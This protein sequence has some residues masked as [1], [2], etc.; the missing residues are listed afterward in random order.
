MIDDSQ[1]QRDVREEL[2]WVPDVD[3][4]NIE[5]QAND[6]IVTLTG[7]V[8]DFKDRHEAECAAK[9][10][11]GVTGVVNEIRI[12]SDS[13]T[14]RSDV[15]L[16]RATIDAIQADLP[17]LSPA[18]QV[19]VS[20]AHVTLEGTVEWLWQR[21]RLESSVRAIAGV[22]TVNNLIVLRPGAMP[23]DVKRR[24]EAAF[25]RSAE[26]DAEQVN[27]EAHAGEITLRGKVSSLREKD[28][29]ER[30]AW[31]APGVRRVDNQ[32]QVVR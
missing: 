31:S 20:N 27:V 11:K 13:A 29:A 3:D 5:V 28:E 14:Q 8:H 26:L 21:Q 24:I 17:A 25:V 2:R 32:I 18:I 7:F 15:A 19:I 23:D 16:A 9:R 6:G 4:A 10:V 30:T 22:A 12:S 1:I